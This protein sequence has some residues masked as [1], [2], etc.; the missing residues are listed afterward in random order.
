MKSF[1]IIY[2][3]QSTHSDEGPLRLKCRKAQ[4]QIDILLNFSL[5]M[6]NVGG[7]DQTLDSLIIESNKG[8]CFEILKYL[9]KVI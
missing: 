6:K 4:D 7:K 5:I 2:N 1:I 8:P 9:V 3:L